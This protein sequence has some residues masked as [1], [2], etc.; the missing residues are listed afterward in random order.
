[1]FLVS[2]YLSYLRTYCFPNDDYDSQEEEKVT[3]YIE[4]SGQIYQ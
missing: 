3:S 1:M 2:A 4:R